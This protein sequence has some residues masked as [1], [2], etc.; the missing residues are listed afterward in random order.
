MIRLAY[1]R[2]VYIELSARL[3]RKYALDLLHL[4]PPHGAADVRERRVDL[5]GGLEQHSRRRTLCCLAQFD[6]EALPAYMHVD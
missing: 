2:H 4:T 6:G 5:V 3:R 1:H